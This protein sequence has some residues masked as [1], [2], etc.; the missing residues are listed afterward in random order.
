MSSTSSLIKSVI[1]DMDGTLFIS[2]FNW[3]RIKERLGVKEGLILDY[4]HSLPPEEK[5]EKFLLLENMEREAVSMGKPAPGVD[6][7]LSVLKRRGL[8]LG[9]LTNNSRALAEKILSRFPINFDALI[10][11]DDGIWKPYPEAVEKALNRLGT[12]P[13]HTVYVG[14]NR[15]DIEAALPF[16]FAKIL[17]I[18]GSP[19]LRRKYGEKV[20][21]LNSFSE[22]LGEI[23][24]GEMLNY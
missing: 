12:N 6:Q 4:L 10:T 8:K 14:D 22:I 3:K 1:F 16:K 7:V 18:N 5:R 2:P 11:R 24:P 23:L 19:H 9:V 17:I 15:L 20:I 13:E 21:F